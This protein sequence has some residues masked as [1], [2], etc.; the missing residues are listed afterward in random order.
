M[1]SDERLTRNYIDNFENSTVTKTIDP[2]P[3]LTSPFEK[4]ISLDSFSCSTSNF[5]VS[6]SGTLVCDSLANRSVL[7]VDCD[8][9]ELVCK[10]IKSVMVHCLI[11]SSQTV[12]LNSVGFAELTD[13]YKDVGIKVNGTSHIDETLDISMISNES[14]VSLISGS[15]IRLFFDLSCGF[16]GTSCEIS[17]LKVEVEF[18]NRLQDEIDAVHNRM[19]GELES[20]YDKSEVNEKFDDYYDKETI[21]AIIEGGIDT[22]NFLTKTLEDDFSYVGKDEL[23]V[24]NLA[25]NTDW[26]FNGD[27][28]YYTNTFQGESTLLI[29]G[30][31]LSSWANARLIYIGIFAN[32]IY[33]STRLKIKNT[34]FIFNNK[35]YYTSFGAIYDLDIFDSNYVIKNSKGYIGNYGTFEGAIPVHLKKLTTNQMSSF[36]ANAKFFITFES[37]IEQTFGIVLY[38]IMGITGSRRYDEIDAVIDRLQK[39]DT[40]GEYVTEG[41][42]NTKL[43]SYQLTQDKIQHWQGGGTSGGRPT[44]ENLYPSA[45]LLWDSL[46]TRQ[47][48]LVSGTNIKT[49][50]NQ[51]ILGN[52]NINI[53]G[54]TV[55]DALSDTSENPVQNKVINTALNGKAPKNHRSSTTDYGVGTSTQYGHCKTINNL[56]QS[57]YIDGYSLSA[58]QGKVL[59]D[60][61]DA[62]ANSTHT[63]TK[64]E[65]TDFPTIPSKTSDLTND[66]DGSN[67]FVKDNDSRL[68]DARTPTNHT[69]GDLTNDGKITTSYVEKDTNDFPVV[70]DNSDGKKLKRGQIYTGFVWDNYARPNIGTSAQATQTVINNAI[71]KKMGSLESAIPLKTSDLTNDGDGSN[72]F[73]KDNDSRLSDNRNPSSH[74]LAPTSTHLVDLNNVRGTGFYFALG[75][76]NIQYVSNL[77]IDW[78]NISFYLVVEETNNATYCKQTI[79]SYGGDKMFVRTRWGSGWTDWRE[80]KLIAPVHIVYIFEDD[81]GIDKSSVTFGSSINLRN[82]GTSTVTWNNEGYYIITQTGSQ[83]ESMM[84]LNDLTGTTEDFCVEYDSYCEQVGGSSGFVIYNNANN[85]VKLTDDCSSDRRLW[86]GYN[87]GSFNETALTGT[88]TT[89]QKWLHYK[90]TIQG[91]NFKMEIYNGSNQIFT[92]SVTLPSAITISNTTQFGIDSEWQRNTKT[93]YKNIKAY[94]I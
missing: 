40:I 46:Q 28:R 32:Y 65:I 34:G 22:S 13:T 26:N 43:K 53:N 35:K 27:G 88:E 90:F 81:G 49:I 24:D 37:D 3:S 25:H 83:K 2:Y 12:T 77:P 30:L 1:V 51:N 8:L 11:S 60:L 56:T 45:I 93:R 44:N 6:D 36:L 54:G 18:E 31:D 68:S 86:Y 9:S 20:Y 52:G 15:S 38:M 63:H 29:D 48:L 85:W 72:V 87:T 80:I 92:Y 42:L 39:S 84:V 57:S 10:D 33:D 79:T 89:Y 66:G 71:D 70:A 73:V 64:S 21:D 94:L 75:N 76:A 4:V 16:L 41:E 58:Y 61:I 23:S 50:N 14:I 5:Y 19:Q 91:R 67:V 74:N 7:Y 47:P 78:G 55:D 69:H 59:K 17:G 62:K 82:G